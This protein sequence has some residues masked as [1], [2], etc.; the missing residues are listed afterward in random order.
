MPIAEMLCVRRFFLKIFTFKYKQMK[1]EEIL[2]II[3]VLSV[4]YSI[5]SYF[6]LRLW[7]K[8]CELLEQIKKN[9]EAMIEN[10]KKRQC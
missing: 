1:T 2:F 9:H 6:E 8:K 10:L 7:K 4:A 5:I 3:F